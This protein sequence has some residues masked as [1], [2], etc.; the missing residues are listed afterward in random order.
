M[1][2]TDSSSSAA[3]WHAAYPA[4]EAEPVDISREDVLELLKA[5]ND[6]TG[7]GKNFVLVDLRRTDYEV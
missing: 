6:E 5:S 3:P 4:P 7:S 1:P 2:V